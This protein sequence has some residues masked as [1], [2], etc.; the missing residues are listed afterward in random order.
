[1]PG[2]R[3]ADPHALGPARAQ[4]VADDPRRDERRAEAR[5]DDAGGLPHPGAAHVR[6]EVVVVRRGVR[7]VDVGVAGVPRPDA[8][9]A[10]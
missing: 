9:G 5:G 6:V 1:M 10:D 7:G 3:R 8:D 4:D 2:G